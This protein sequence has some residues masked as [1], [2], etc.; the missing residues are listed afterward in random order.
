M[1]LSFIIII[2]IIITNSAGKGMGILWKYMNSIDMCF[3]LRIIYTYEAHY[4]AGSVSEH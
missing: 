4:Q 1:F 3:A 2:I